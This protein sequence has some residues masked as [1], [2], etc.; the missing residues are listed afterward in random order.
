MNKRIKEVR[1]YFGK[2][3]EE[4]SKWLGIGKSAMSDIESGRRNVTEQHIIMLC[5]RNINEEWLRTG[6]GD[7][8]TKEFKEYTELKEKLMRVVSELTADELKA[9]NK[10]VEILKKE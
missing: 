10:V 5:A 9:I 2:N 4:F 8:F 7:M 6:E 3:Q 1:L